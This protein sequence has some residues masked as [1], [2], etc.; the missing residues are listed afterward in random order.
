M[1]AGQF[2][3]PLLAALSLAM[4]AVADTIAVLRENT[5]TL[6]Q[7]DGK[8]TTIRVGEGQE[9]EQW[10]AAGMWA[11]GTWEL[12]EQRGFCWTARGQSTLCINMPASAGVGETW[13]VRGPTG[14]VVWRAEI[15]EGRADLKALSQ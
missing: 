1:R 8:V 10:N 9:L 15:V 4:P 2:L 11:A 7:Q 14:Q 6:T 5:L 3:V 13:E 12:D